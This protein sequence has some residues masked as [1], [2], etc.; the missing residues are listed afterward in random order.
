MQFNQI[1]FKL[2]MRLKLILKKFK[3]IIIFYKNTNITLLKIKNFIRDIR[4]DNIILR[5]TS[6]YKLNQLIQNKQF[7]NVLFNNN[8]ILKILIYK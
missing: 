5:A 7:V 1:L 3:Q 2:N 4:Q 6:V 8:K